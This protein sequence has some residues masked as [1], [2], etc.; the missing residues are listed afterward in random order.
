MK[1]G[2]LG[3]S[4]TVAV[5]G[6][7]VLVWGAE[8]AVSTASFGLLATAIQVA[9][10][11]AVR[12]VWNAGFTRMLARWGMGMGLRLLGVVMIVVAVTVNRELFQPLPAAFGYL[13]VLIPLL[14]VETKLIT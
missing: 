10:V 14:F 11:A 2:V 3:F 4:L 9:S 13:G 1:T 5:T 6:T 8:T 7:L 12:P